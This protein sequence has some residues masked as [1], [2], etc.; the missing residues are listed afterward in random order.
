M[1]CCAFLAAMLVSALASAFT[2]YFQNPTFDQP[3]VPPNVL[4][5]NKV[6]AGVTTTLAGTTISL[7]DLSSPPVTIEI[8]ATGSALAVKVNGAP[9][10][11]ATDTSITAAGLV[12]LDGVRSVGQPLYLDN[13]H[14][15]GAAVTL[16]RK[17]EFD[18]AGSR[19][20]C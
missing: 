1:R 8:S 4:Q 6:L 20:S 19:G 17:A 2:N 3:E 16:V 5:L 14:A 18:R 7:P 13:L 12:G 10:L 9:T 15:V 11:S